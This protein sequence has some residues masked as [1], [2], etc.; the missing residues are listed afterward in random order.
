MAK[1][2]VTLKIM[3]E[4]VKSNLDSVEIKIK[5]ILKGKSDQFKVEKEP[6][7]FGLSSLKFMFVWDEAFGGT[8]E[9]EAK[10]KKIKGVASVNMVDVRRAIG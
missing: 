6:I 9:V 8:D 3:P 7:A 10:I 2:V 1:V 5:E 4:N